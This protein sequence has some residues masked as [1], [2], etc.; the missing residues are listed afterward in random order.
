MSPQ[1]EPNYLGYQSPLFTPS[2]T[3]L[4]AQGVLIRGIAWLI[5][6]VVLGIATTA[7]F[8]PTILGVH[9]AVPP[10]VFFNRAIISEVLGATTVYFVYFT[11]LEGRYGQTLG[12]FV[13]EIKVVREDGTQVGYRAAALRTIL[14]VIDFLPLL[15]AMGALLIESSDK[16]Q[17]LG[18]I[19][20][21]TIVISHVRYTSV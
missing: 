4:Q 14:R 3:H 17:R 13:S 11:V 8:V 6:S 15:Y 5:D 18:D 20:A 7:V 2:P 9:V 1:Q 16:R 19:V 12:K 10:S 21:H